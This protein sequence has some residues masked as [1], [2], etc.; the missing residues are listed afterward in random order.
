MSPVGVR[1]HRLHRQVHVKPDD[2]GH[3]LLELGI[4]GDLECIDTGRLQG[5]RMPDA[6]YARRADAPTDSAIYVRAS[7]SRQAASRAQPF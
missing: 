6:F 1:H 3:L 4:I 5:G 2:V 7:A